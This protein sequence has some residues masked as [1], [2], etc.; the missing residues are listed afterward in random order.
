V[1]RDYAHLAITFCPA[2][3]ILA[4]Y[5]ENV[6]A[7]YEHGV[8]MRTRSHAAFGPE[9]KRKRGILSRGPKRCWSAIANLARLRAD[10]IRVGSGFNALSVPPTAEGLR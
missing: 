7:N 9:A 6:Q 8:C 4:R 5:S 10:R 2:M 3:H 1:R